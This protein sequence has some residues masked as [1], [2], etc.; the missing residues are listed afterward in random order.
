M[1]AK[2]VAKEIALNKVT[3]DVLLMRVRS[4]GS[5]EKEAFPVI[6]EESIKEYQYGWLFYYNSTKYIE[7][8]N[9]DDSYIGNAPLFVSKIDASTKYIGLSLKGDDH[10]V[11][12]H[13]IDR[14][15]I[16]KS[17]DQS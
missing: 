4:V 17:S 2:E 3:R 11:Y 12:Q 16:L 9:N 6:Q 5:V 13:C 7:S 15:Y 1:I 10:A 8:G 14:G